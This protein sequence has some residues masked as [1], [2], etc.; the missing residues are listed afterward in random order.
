ME[1]I[2]HDLQ[3][4]DV[5]ADD[6]LPLLFQI[7]KGL[8]FMHQR[9]FAHRDLKPANI[10]LTM[11]GKRVLTAK[12][13][14]FGSSKFL[15]QEQARSYHGTSIYM[16]PEFFEAVSYDNAVDMWAMGVIAL[17]VLGARD[18]KAWDSRFP[19]TQTQHQEWVR[20]VLEPQI[21]KA[22]ERLRPMISGLITTDPERR[23]TAKTTH[24]W[25]R[26]SGDT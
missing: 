3:S 9:G 7:V 19:P 1:W 2:E 18:L 21:R 6:V 17:H 15:D 14:D 26:D 11:D 24:D 25:F 22:P 5:E 23:W 20:E 4:V 8:L 10:L 13:A 12:I 16:A